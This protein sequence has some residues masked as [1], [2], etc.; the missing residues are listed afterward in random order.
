GK[1]NHNFAARKTEA[2]P[3]SGGEQR[4]KFLLYRGVGNFAVP[5]SARLLEDGRVAVTASS[6]RAVGDVMLFQNTKGAIS[7]Q[8]AQSQ[9]GE[10]TLTPPSGATTAQSVRATLERMLVEHGLYAKEAAAMVETWRDSW[11]EE[12]ARLFYVVPQA[13]VDEILPLEV[14]PAPQSGA[15]VFVGRIELITPAILEEVHT[16][17]QNRDRATIL[18]YGRF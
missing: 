13:A 16:A 17:L 10:I 2:W 5:V 1:S 8:P 18:K 14:T 15:R 9:A 3:G 11:F 4:E 7:A 6:G 12:G